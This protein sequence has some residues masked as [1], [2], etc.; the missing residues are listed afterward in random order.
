MLLCVIWKSNISPGRVIDVT[1]TKLLVQPISRC[2]HTA[3]NPP[4]CVSRHLTFGSTSPAPVSD[5]LRLS[6]S[7]VRFCFVL[8]DWKGQP[9][10]MS[11]TSDGLARDAD[12][13]LSTKRASPSAKYSPSTCQ[14]TTRDDWKRDSTTQ[15]VRRDV[16]NVTTLRGVEMAVINVN[17]DQSTTRRK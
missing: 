5:V 11:V 8:F 14:Q 4:D 12:C 2:D 7:C 3:L 1:S 17:E 16:T 9:A 10:C 15:I 6:L 13:S